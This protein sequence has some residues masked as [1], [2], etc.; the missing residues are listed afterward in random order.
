MYPIHDH[1][2][3]VLLATALAAKRRPAE[4]LEIMAAIDL[5]QGN[6]PNEEKLSE[7]FARLGQNGLL[8]ARDGGV[9]LT[10]AAESQ[11]EALR[12]ESGKS[13]RAFSKEKG[14]DPK[15]LSRYLRN[16]VPFEKKPRRI[17]KPMDEDM[18]KEI[19][20]W[21]KELRKEHIAVWREDVRTKALEIAGRKGHTTFKASGSWIGRFMKRNR[22]SMRKVTPNGH[23]VVFTE[24]DIVST[25]TL[26]HDKPYDEDKNL[27]FHCCCRRRKRSSWIFS[28]ITETITN[29]LTTHSS[30][31]IR[32]AVSWLLRN[33]KR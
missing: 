5:I 23:K 19:A 7:A 2:P 22:F 28:P 29:F 31:W 6:I 4:L 10:P 32:Q 27:Q 18:E 1:D 25:I 12:S 13:K 15:T 8:V 24:Q 9:A 11:I 3:L 21:I 17:P 26:V 14:F 20:E 33:P 30:T 16:D